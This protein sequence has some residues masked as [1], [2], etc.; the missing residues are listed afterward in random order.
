M[1]STTTKR[2]FLRRTTALFVQ[3]LTLVLFAFFREGVPAKA[4]EPADW[5]HWRGPQRNGIVQE[6]SGWNGG[7]WMSENPVWEAAVGEGSTSPL[8]VG[9]RLYVMGWER[10]EDHIRCLEAGTGKPLWNVSYKCPQYG[11]YAIGDEDAYS[12]PTS[13]PEYDPDTGYLFT[14]SCDGDLN[15]WDTSA[16]GKKVWGV[17]LYERFHVGPRPACNLEKNDLRDYGYT[18]APY[19]NG[20]LVIVEAGSHEGSVMALDKRTGQARWGSEYCGPAGHTGGLAPITVEGV[21]C[22]AV[23]NLYVLLVLRLDPGHEGKT[24]ATYPWKSAFANNDLTP[25]VQGD[26]VLISSG[27]TH[28]SICKVKF[29]LHAATQLW[30]QPYSSFVGSPVI[31]GDSVYMACER[32]L[33]LDWD[34]GKLVWEGGSFGYG[35]ACIVTGDGKVIVWSNLG[36]VTL[37]DGAR[38]SPTVFKPLAR[39]A[40][41]VESGQAWPHPVLAGHRLYCKDRKGRLVCLTGAGPT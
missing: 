26:C 39:I 8:I 7:R 11:R 1:S 6:S 23:L 18:T 16:L 25:T 40:R 33:C 31:D 21:P 22:L 9:G 2:R 24:V 34:T 37:V 12:G 41:V 30:E 17:N 15:C 3:H 38:E 28:N 4:A 29:T 13:A 27:H 20:N 14:L 5:L 32:L 10:G 19:V 36:K 35:G